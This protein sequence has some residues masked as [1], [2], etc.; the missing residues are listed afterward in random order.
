[1]PE[2]LRSLYRQRLRWY[3]GASEVLLKRRDFCRYPAGF[4]HLKALDFPL[5][6]MNDL[7]IPL[8][9]F[10]AMISIAIAI[11]RGLVLPLIVQVILF[12]TLQVLI[13]LISLQIAEER[14]V[15]LAVVPLF[16][17]GC[18][19]FH[20]VLMLKCSLDVL[21]ARSRSFGWTFTERE[22][23]EDKVTVT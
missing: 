16:A 2:R 10:L 12:S 5:V 9:D 17:I 3:R 6:I 11:T 14:D 15:S 21:Y 7:M 18:R 23:R 13:A 8:I 19:Q 1:M 22:G 4:G 20:E